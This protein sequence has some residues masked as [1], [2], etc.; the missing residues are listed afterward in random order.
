[1]RRPTRLRIRANNGPRAASN[2]QG[3]MIIIARA[4]EITNRDYNRASRTTDDSEVERIY[5]HAYIET[6]GRETFVRHQPPIFA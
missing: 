2:R 3:L 5:G 1:M 6:I 4:I